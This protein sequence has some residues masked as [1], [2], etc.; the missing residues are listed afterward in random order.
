MNQNFSMKAFMKKLRSD[1]LILALGMPMGYMPGMPV[2]H[3]QKDEVCITIPFFTRRISRKS[4][5]EKDIS[6]NVVETYPVRYSVTYALRAITLP[7]FDSSKQSSVV[8]ARNEEF[9]AKTITEGKVIAFSDLSYRED[10]MRT[11]NGER[12]PISPQK[13]IGVFRSDKKEYEKQLEEIYVLY[14][15]AINTRLYDNKID[16]AAESRLINK[17]I[18]LLDHEPSIRPFYLFLDGGS[19]AKKLSGAE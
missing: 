18:A 5:K 3:N 6:F 13:P 11:Y 19:F 8:L 4:V 15:K 2:I 7:E 16:G 17:L 10:Y 9:L 12:V 1:E 14:D